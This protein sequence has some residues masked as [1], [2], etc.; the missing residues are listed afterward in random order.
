MRL[1]SSAIT[2]ICIPDNERRHLSGAI[3][4][5]AEVCYVIPARTITETSS[6]CSA[7][8]RNSS[9]L[10]FR[11]DISLP[12]ESVINDTERLSR[13]LHLQ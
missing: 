1:G 9:S 6:G 8:E 7:C 12:Y 10:P 5:F 2:A 3:S 13:F 11:T 4:G